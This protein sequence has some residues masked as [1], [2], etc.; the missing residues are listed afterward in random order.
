[1]VYLGLSRAKANFRRGDDMAKCLEGWKAVVGYRHYLGL[2]GRSNRPTANWR[3][4][5]E[6]YRMYFIFFIQGYHSCQRS[7][8]PS[9]STRLNSIR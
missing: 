6:S 8:N 9:P 4:T 2:N 7:L 5:P 3:R 1:M